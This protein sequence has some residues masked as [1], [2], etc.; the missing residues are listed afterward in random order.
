MAQ[1]LAEC[2]GRHGGYTAAA[3]GRFKG[4]YITRHY[5]RPDQGIHAV[6]LELSQI[7]YMQETRPY[8]YDEALAARVEPLLETLLDEAL[9]RLSLA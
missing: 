9:I 5:G 7:T 6:Q 1:A 4:G 3:N 8:A 2:V